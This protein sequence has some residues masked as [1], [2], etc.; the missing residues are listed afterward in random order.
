[1]FQGKEQAEENSG[2]QENVDSGQDTFKPGSFRLILID[3]R[4]K[5]RRFFGVKNPIQSDKFNSSIL[6]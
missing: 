4:L 2:G 6:L 1:M 3:G 5:I